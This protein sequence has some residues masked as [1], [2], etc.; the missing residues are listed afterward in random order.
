MP[1]LQWCR[2][3]HDEIR[4]SGFQCGS[5][6]LGFGGPHISAVADAVDVL[7]D[8]PDLVDVN[9]ARG[10]VSPGQHGQAQAASIETANAWSTTYRRIQAVLT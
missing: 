1:S 2:L 4:A 5:Q 7:V 8:M 6:I 10:D 9:S 3:T